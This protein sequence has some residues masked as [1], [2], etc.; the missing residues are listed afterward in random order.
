[1]AENVASRA[2]PVYCSE[3][4]Q[5]DTPSMFGTASQAEVW[6]LLEY[7]PPWG[8]QAF[9]ECTLPPAVKERISAFLRATPNSRL[10]LIHQDP[11]RL[12]SGIAMFLALSREVDPVLVRVEL[13][14]YEDLLDL[15]L[16]SLLGNGLRLDGLRGEETVILVC[17]N[18]R[19]DRCCGRLGAPVYRELSGPESTFVWQTVHVGGHRFAANLVC[20]PHGIY[21]GRVEPARARS[22]VEDFREGR[23]ALDNFRGRSCYSP[24]TQA[25]EGFLRQR[26]GERALDAYRLAGVTQQSSGIV[27][28]EFRAR[29]DGKLERVEVRAATNRQEKM[30]GCTP[31]KWSQP[32]EFELVR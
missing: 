12:S 21:Y 32:E 2:S 24:V 22:V 27:T 4:C 5:L 29:T 14:S 11:R 3:A 26:S 6:L 28:V 15:D 8:A 23:L 25:A 31:P 10:Q 20:L 13:Q 17:T 9:E 16:A 7:S 30:M 1:M 18:A 19:R